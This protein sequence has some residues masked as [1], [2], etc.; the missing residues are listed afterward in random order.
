MGLRFQFPLIWFPAEQYTPPYNV[1]P[2]WWKDFVLTE[3]YKPPGMEMAE[4]YDLTQLHASHSQSNLD[5]GR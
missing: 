4:E 3:G 1:D 2:D 5:L